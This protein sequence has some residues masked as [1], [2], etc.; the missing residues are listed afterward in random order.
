M[1]IKNCVRCGA[2][3]R[4]RGGKPCLQ[5]AMANGRCYYHGGRCTGPKT[6]EGKQKCKTVNVKHGYYSR[7]SIEERRS[8]RETLKEFKN[9]IH[10]R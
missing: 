5:V 10:S 2:K 6:N 7:E 1:S 9:D 4:S 3:A 8:F